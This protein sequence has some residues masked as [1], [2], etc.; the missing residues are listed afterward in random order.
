MVLL[1]DSYDHYT[2]PFLPAKYTQLYAPSGTTACTVGAFGRRSTQAVRCAG[3]ST[4]PALVIPNTRDTVAV[5]SAFRLNGSFGTLTD[6]TVT[7]GS[8][9]GNPPGMSPSLTPADSF[10]P[11]VT[12]L[13]IFRNSQRG[14]V[15]IG[16]S[17]DGTMYAARGTGDLNVLD[18]DRLVL[19]VLGR[20]T[21]ALQSNTYYYIEA[22]VRIHDTLG[23]VEIRVNGDVW[24]ALTGVD[25]KPD[26]TFGYSTEIC[27]GMIRSATAT[28]SG[29]FDD[30]YIL[31]T[32]A[33]V[34]VNTPVDF[35]GDIEV[36]YQQPIVDVVRD[37]TPLVGIDHFAMVDEIPPDDDV[38]YNSTETLNA[39]DTF[40]T[41]PAPV[42]G[43]N[44]VAMQV[45]YD[46]RRTESGNTSTAPVFRVGGVNYAGTAQGNTSTYTFQRGI[47]T[48]NPATLAAITDTV[49]NASSVGYKKTA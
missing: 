10:S 11:S 18:F 30:L 23:T 16:V 27:Y 1:L 34:A 2:T 21:L 47:W 35:L 33:S 6:D 45:I 22:K 41:E 37:W 42:V 25:T 29:D 15:G 14:Q 31:N 5:G 7:A 13:W 24:L 12:M 3:R 49:F 36:N 38:T 19:P 43:A 48:R 26:T 17:K 40:Q 39:V 8:G 4:V 44:V 9:I 32:D 46:V 28:T 20:T